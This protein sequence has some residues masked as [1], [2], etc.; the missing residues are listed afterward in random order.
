MT[1]LIVDAQRAITNET[2]YRFEEFVSNVKLLIDTARKC[3]LEVIYIR[4]DDGAG[5]PLSKG[6]EGFEIYDGFRPAEGEKIFD[7][8]VNSPF[9]D[10]GL[11]E[12]LKGKNETELI[13][14]GL[15][16]DYCI[17]AAVKC[18]FE[19]GFHIIVPEY[20]NST[21]D[22]EFMTAE[23]SYKYYNRFMWSGRY[24]DCIS[25]E[26]MLCIMDMKKASFSV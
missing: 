9:R 24:A 13:I 1:L 4:H 16:T 17:D 19:H 15:Q 8:T 25:M 21:F 14:A 12:Y 26:E 7:K 18:G 10:T 2:L 11:T 6:N 23:E 5:E 20:S 3:K 22:N